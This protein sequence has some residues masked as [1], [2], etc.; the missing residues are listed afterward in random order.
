M[1]QII[2][3]MESYDELIFQML[4]LVKHYVF[5]MTMGYL[6]GNIQAEL[7]VRDLHEIALLLEKWDGKF[8]VGIFI[9]RVKEYTIENEIRLVISW[10]Q[11]IY[12]FVSRKLIGVNLK[13][14]DKG[15]FVSRFSSLDVSM[16][17][18]RILFDNP[19]V[20][21][22]DIINNLQMSALT[23]QCIKKRDKGMRL[24]KYFKW[25]RM[26]NKNVVYDNRFGTY[27][28]SGKYR[29]NVFY[30]V[31]FCSLW[32][33]RYLYFHIKMEDSN[34]NFYHHN[35][36]TEVLEIKG[37]DYIRLH[38]DTNKRGQGEP[39]VRAYNLK[40]YYNQSGNMEIFIEEEFH[41]VGGG[42]HIVQKDICR[43]SVK[44]CANKYYLYIGLPWEIL[45]YHPEPA[46]ELYFDVWLRTD[47]FIMEWQSAYHA[48]YD[49]SEYSRLRL[50]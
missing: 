21:A 36:N 25:T 6:S 2:P 39:F 29:S 17:I 31:H 40:P 20:V 18:Q 28:V 47:N 1:A 5:E 48:W 22:S 16:N 27:L 32:D 7:N 34:A 24:G 19:Q 13:R 10:L 3:Q 33:E 46:F 44:R 50:C 42:I 43:T 8:N 30:C 11:D 38:F 35:S 14:R 15:C 9:E 12:P 23:M 37:Y 41:C 4:H 45:Q 49:I 26:D